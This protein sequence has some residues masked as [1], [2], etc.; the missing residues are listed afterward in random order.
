QGVAEGARLV[1]GGGRPASCPK[2]WFVEPTLFADV[3]NSMTIARE[4][5]F[6]SVLAVIPHDGD[7]DA[8]RIANDSDYGLSAAVPCA[9]PHRA[10]GARGGPGPHKGRH[11]AG[12]RR[13]LRRLQGERRRPPERH[14][15]SRGVPRDQDPDRPR[16]GVVPSTRG[17]P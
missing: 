8:V 14:R 4:E 2:G 10:P 11:R 5:I 16:R 1:T 7:D 15:R 17:A 6:G 3:D 12:P 13:A 9:P